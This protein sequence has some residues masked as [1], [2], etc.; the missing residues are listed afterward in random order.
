MVYLANPT[1]SRD[2][3]TVVCCAQVPASRLAGREN[4]LPRAATTQLRIPCSLHPSQFHPS[5]VLPPQV[6]QAK[7]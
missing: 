2:L 6:S 4:P 5:A 1:R 7:K 3:R